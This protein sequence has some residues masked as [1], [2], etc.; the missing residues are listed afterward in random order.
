MARSYPPPTPLFHWASITAQI[1]LSV[2]LL[3]LASFYFTCVPLPLWTSINKCHKL[4]SVEL[5][6]PASL[7]ASVRRPEAVWG[8]C[9]MQ[10]HCTLSTVYSLYYISLST[11]IIVIAI[12]IIYIYDIALN[13]TIQDNVSYKPTARRS[14]PLQTALQSPSSLYPFNQNE[15]QKSESIMPKAKWPR[16]TGIQ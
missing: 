4:C 6:H 7:V 14:V 15:T 5:F 12:I 3:F 10:T 9:I 13:S 16:T 8:L 11:D 2:L 1:S